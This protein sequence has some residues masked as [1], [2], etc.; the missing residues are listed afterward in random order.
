MFADALT[1]SNFL[2]IKVADFKK[3]SLSKKKLFD[4][5]LDFTSRCYRQADKN[6]IQ[7]DFGKA[8]NAL[9]KI[10]AKV[11]LRA[12]SSDIV[13]SLPSRH[14][15]EALED[16]RAQLFT[17]TSSNVAVNLATEGAASKQAKSKKNRAPGVDGFT[18]EHLSS[19]LL[20][21]NRDNQLKDKLLKEYT[22]L[23]Q[24]LLTGSLTSPHQ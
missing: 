19:L 22:Q 18:I 3:K 23:L 14:L 20:G 11:N 8:M 4:R 7:G 2:N 10:D 24:K 15:N 13:A 21:G 17:C 1:S 9:L 5:K 16:F 6:A 12:A